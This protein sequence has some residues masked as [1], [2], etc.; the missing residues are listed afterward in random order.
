MPLLA[1]PSPESYVMAH[2]HPSDTSDPQAYSSEDALSAQLLEHPLEHYLVAWRRYPFPLD[3]SAH[4][5]RAPLGA[6]AGLDYRHLH[7]EIGFGDGRY[8][9]RRALQEPEDAFVGLEISSASVAR[10]LRRLKRQ[11]QSNVRLLKVGAYFALQQLFAPH[12]LRSIVVNF[13]DPWPKERHEK[14]RLLQRR[15]FQLAASRLEPEGELRLATDHPAYLEFACA[16]A[17]ASGLFSLH[18][19]QAPEAVFETK[20]ALKWKSQGKPLYYQIFRYHG[21]TSAEFPCLERDAIMPHAIVRGRLPETLH[22]HKQVLAYADGHVIL[23]EACRSLSAAPAADA[24][25]LLIRATIDE[26]DFKQQLLVIVQRHSLTQANDKANNEGDS[27]D[28][29]SDDNA[30]TLLPG[31]GDAF[32][33]RLESFGDPIITKTARGAVHAVTEWLLADPQ[34]FRVLR[35]AY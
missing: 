8:T 15:F 34:G 35:R 3:W 29:N 7:L 6:A 1:R 30:L 25:R 2:S 20:Y 14:N 23:H 5:A 18:Q 27:D 11:Q 33:V 19:G 13:P 31:E 16:E 21:A 28:G 17:E 26:P 4:F 24:P 22:F 12:S 10:A 9:V 32:I